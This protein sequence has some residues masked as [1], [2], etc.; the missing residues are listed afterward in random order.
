M[1]WI[2]KQRR[3]CR[4]EHT[5]PGRPIRELR[6]LSR[7]PRVQENGVH[8]RVDSGRQRAVIEALLEHTPTQLT[9]EHNV[10]VR[11]ATQLILDPHGNTICCRSAREVLDSFDLPRTLGRVVR[12]WW[13]WAKV[14]GG[15]HDY[16]LPH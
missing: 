11:T 7:D 9:I 2:R 13:R 14:V 4:I 15:W 12:R 10:E 6:V 16:V 3:N 5:R 1:W 8:Q